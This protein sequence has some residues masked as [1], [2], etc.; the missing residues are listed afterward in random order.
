MRL[1]AVLTALAL[2]VS[3][4]PVLATSAS[5]APVTAPVVGLL[6]AGKTDSGQRGNHIRVS[7]VRGLNPAGDTLVVRG[8]GFDE[9]VGIYVALCVTPRRGQ[10]PSP[11]GGG[12][13]STGSVASAWISS[14]APPFAQGVT[15]PYRPG[16][17][18]EVTI[19]V[20]ALIGTVD[21]R[22]VS[23]AI[24]TRADHLR[25]S[26]RRWDLVVPVHFR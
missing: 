24:V 5:A 26:D 1:C 7:R 4:G 23:C 8:R 11:C 9:T 22:R 13:N 17:R 12:I 16:G 10:R 19:S 21:C 3:G 15:T 6:T 18:F 25:G 20:R 14:N 2:A